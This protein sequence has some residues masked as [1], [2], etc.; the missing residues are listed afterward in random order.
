M[1]SIGAFRLNK[2]AIAEGEWIEVGAD[3]AK[4]EIRAR[5]AVSAYRD[6]LAAL[7]EEAARKHNR[8]ARGGETA[9][10][11]DRL[12]PT[13]DDQ[14]QGMALADHIVL[15]VRGLDHDDG[16]PVTVEEYRAMLRDAETYGMLIRFTVEAAIAVQMRHT[17]QV[18]KAT[19]N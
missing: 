10:T 4:F 14:C 12:P 6:G 15:D 9:V 8:K 18:E 13:I 5:G 3:D 1:A 16:K 17:G 19:K 7:R 11:P 2:D